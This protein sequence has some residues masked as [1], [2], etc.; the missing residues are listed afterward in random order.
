[1]SLP[2]IYIPGTIAV[3]ATIG[4]A[5]SPEQAQNLSEIG[6]LR[7]A[8]VGVVVSGG[9]LA[10]KFLSVLVQMT[11]AIGKLEKALDARSERDHVLVTEIA[12]ES[13]KP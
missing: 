1:M 4:A 10:F 9:A 2:P 13:M 5:L 12:K 8:L 3:I 6:F 7:W 11:E